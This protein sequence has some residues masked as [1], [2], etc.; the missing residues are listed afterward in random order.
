MGDVDAVDAGVDVGAKEI[1]SEDTLDASVAK[2]FGVI[3]LSDV[4]DVVIG[5]PPLSGIGASGA[6]L[7]G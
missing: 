7:F 6:L 4:V 2:M 5:A 1:A 3:F